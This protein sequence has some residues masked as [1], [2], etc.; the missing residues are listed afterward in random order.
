MKKLLVLVFFG[1]LCSACSAMA[2]DTYTAPMK[3]QII[4]GEDKEEHDE[5]HGEEEEKH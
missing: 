5:E 1:M 2:M 4:M 3:D